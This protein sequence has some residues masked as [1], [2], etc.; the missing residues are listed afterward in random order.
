MQ[1]CVC[2]AILTKSSFSTLSQSCPVADVLNHGLDEVVR[3]GLLDSLLPF[4]S[5]SN[6]V[7]ASNTGVSASVSSSGPS[8][9]TVTPGGQRTGAG[10]S[11]S[12]IVSGASAAESSSKE[13]EGE[14][15]RPPS[16]ESNLTSMPASHRLSSSD[17]MRR[18][19]GSSS[20]L[21]RMKSSDSSNSL[22]KHRDI[23]K[24]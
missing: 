9:V 18:A 3:Q 16:A 7:T 1:P 22:S 21:G 23:K 17:L 5:S 14:L 24:T 15:Y 6:I 19:H 12:G 20:T 8:S 2:H 10:P 13:E 11:T 4:L